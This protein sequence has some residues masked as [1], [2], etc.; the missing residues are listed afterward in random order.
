MSETLN[1]RRFLAELLLLSSASLQ[2]KKSWAGRTL[3]DRTLVEQH[4]FSDV[5]EKRG[6][7][8]DRRGRALVHLVPRALLAASPNVDVGDERVLATIERLDTNL[9]GHVVRPPNGWRPIGTMLLEGKSLPSL[10]RSA[11]SRMGATA[12]GGTDVFRWI[13]AS[14]WEA[15]GGAMLSPLVGPVSSDGV[16]LGGLQ[17][18]YDNKL[19]SGQDLRTHIDLD[20]QRTLKDFLDR[21]VAPLG[22]AP[23]R[24]AHGVLVCL[25]SGTISALGSR[26]QLSFLADSVAHAPLRLTR[27][28][29]VTDIEQVGGFLTPFLIH[30]YFASNVTGD[31]SACVARARR[32]LY[33]NGMNRSLPKSGVARENPV[34]HFTQQVAAS[35]IS[36]YCLHK[37]ALCD[38]PGAAPTFTASDWK[39]LSWSDLLPGAAI[40]PSLATLAMRLASLVSPNKI[41]RE[42]V[43]SI[44]SDGPRQCG[45]NAS[46]G[47]AEPDL[48]AR[49][50][51]DVYRNQ[52]ANLGWAAEI[53]GDVSRF[54]EAHRTESIHRIQ[55]WATWPADRPAHLLVFSGRV[56][57]RPSN[58]VQ[59]S[60]MHAVTDLHAAM[61]SNG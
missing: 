31:L 15:T 48:L 22:A 26:G 53:A 54:K 28:H 8:L 60:V 39:N 21:L 1:R 50:F 10:E 59:T 56:D 38:F 6:V 42:R 19:R 55:G 18:T 27:V 14:R 57:E 23:F 33:S 2:S 24:N 36:R 44:G 5:L 52:A 11:S 41:E 30:L 47:A 12:D 25:R 43:V 58:A 61:V 20:H 45:M 35:E 17:L 40:A 37:K 9:E 46:P 32:W 34:S 3:M 13:D 16:G 49:S 7:L 4:P 29:P 51:L